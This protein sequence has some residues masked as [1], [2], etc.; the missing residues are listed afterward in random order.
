MFT[1]GAI[2]QHY[3]RE[4]T[5]VKCMPS[6]T[7][8][9][10]DH[11]ANLPYAHTKYPKNHHHN[12]LRHNNTNNNMRSMLLATY[13]ALASAFVPQQQVYT[14]TLLAASKHH[15]MTGDVDVDAKYCADHFGECSLD[16][17]ERI[18]DGRL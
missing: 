5:D 2:F 8:S 4:N 13:A 14:K 1:L 17:M 16:E 3:L 18:R 7:G 9:L 6:A 11:D 12:Y 10:T 15:V